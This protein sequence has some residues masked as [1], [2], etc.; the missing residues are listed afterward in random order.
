MHNLRIYFIFCT[1]LPGEGLIAR[2]A[3]AIVGSGPNNTNANNNDND[4]DNE[5]M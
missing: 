2:L 3:D 1:S 4:D 5:Q